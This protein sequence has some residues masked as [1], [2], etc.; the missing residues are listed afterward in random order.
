MDFAR[1]LIKEE[2]VLV[3]PGTAHSLHLLRYYF[4]QPLTGA[5]VSLAAEN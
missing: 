2:C 4:I 1:E 3:L 5:L